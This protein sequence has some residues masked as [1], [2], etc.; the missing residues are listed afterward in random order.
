MPLMASARQKLGH[1]KSI[2]VHSMG[3]DEITPL[4]PATVLEV[5]PA[6]IK[7]YTFEPTAYGFKQCSIEDLQ[8]GD[9]FMNAKILRLEA[10]R[11]NR[12]L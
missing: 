12:I 2:V 11:M 8:G 5:T 3:L 9:R 4:G 10:M 1:Q 7:N 6:G